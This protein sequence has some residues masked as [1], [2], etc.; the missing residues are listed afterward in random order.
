MVRNVNRL[1][2]A[3]KFERK[4]VERY[5]EAAGLPQRVAEEVAERVEHKVKNITR[6]KV[7]GQ[8]DLE[9][10]KLEKDLQR[11]ASTYRKKDSNC[12]SE[13]KT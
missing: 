4:D 1:S 5:L 9:L 13:L 8:I 6:T 7:N 10:K 2:E 3:E 12:K 11:A